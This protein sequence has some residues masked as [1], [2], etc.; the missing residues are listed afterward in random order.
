MKSIKKE[1]SGIFKDY[2]EKDKMKKCRE[3][4]KEF[5]QKGSAKF[6]RKYCE[7]C[8]KKRKDDYENLWQVSA[9]DCEED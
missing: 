5:V 1:N 9:D 7:S 8:S 2:K 4:G 3:C 6:E